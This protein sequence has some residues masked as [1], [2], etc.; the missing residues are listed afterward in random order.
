MNDTASLTP[1]FLSAPIDVVEF[2]SAVCA[3][4]DD[5]DIAYCMERN[6]SGYPDRITGDIDMVVQKSQLMEARAKLVAIAESAGWQIFYEFTW[7][8]VVHVGFT[9][10]RHPDRYALVFELFCGGIWKGATFLS[11]DEVLSAR[12]KY[13][14]TWRPRAAHEA[15]LTYV[16]HLLYNSKVQEKYRDRLQHLVS[17]D[18]QEFLKC[19]AKRFGAESAAGHVKAICTGDWRYSQRMAPQLRRQLLMYSVT[20]DFAGLLR[21]VYLRYV[22]GRDQVAGPLIFV[23]SHDQRLGDSISVKLLDITTEWHL[24]MPGK[25]LLLM[26]DEINVSGKKKIRVARRILSAG[27]VVILNGMHAFQGQFS[28]YGLY[29]QLDIGSGEINLLLNGV[30]VISENMDVH[31]MTPSDLAHRVWSEVLRH[32]ATMAPIK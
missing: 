15:L 1:A 32:S 8:R 20:S 28:G 4:F 24:F 3:G 10:T 17:T 29:C 25:K 9:S 21:N 30:S 2:L 7:A 11:A 23:R 18:Q 5:T 6:Y 14:L 12:Q 22:A 19:F 13:G 31:L 26:A 27:G 16:H